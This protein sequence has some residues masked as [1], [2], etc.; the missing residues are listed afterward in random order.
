[1]PPRTLTTS[2]PMDCP[3]T[4]AL[5]VCVDAERVVAIRAGG[6]HPDTNGFICTKISRFDRRLEHSD[7]LLYPLRR[8][9]LKGEGAFER[10]TWDEAVREITRRFK[11]IRHEWGGEAIL[12]Y[13]YGGSN[14]ALTD[15]FADRL[16]FARLGASRLDKTICAA[17]TTALAVA[18]YG[19]MPGVAFGDFPEARCIVVWG[20]NPR[21]SNIHLMPFL[22]EAKRRG[23]FIAVVDPVRNFSTRE[24][25]LHLPVRPGGDLPLA[26]ALIRWWNERGMLDRGFL[27]RHADGLDTLL[28]AAEEWSLERA[29]GEAGLEAESILRLAEAYAELSPALI[30]IGWGLER[31][32]N[33]GHAVA[34]IL[35]MPA[36][37]GKFGVRGGGYTLSNNG[38]V[39]FDSDEVLG[40]HGWD[41]RKVN[42]TR[43]GEAL[44][45]GFDPPIKGLF[46]YNCNPAVSVPDQGA[47]LAGLARG[48]LFTVVLDQVMTDTARYADVVLPATTFLEHRDVRV[49]YGAYVV[50]G[51]APVVAR[52][53]EAKPNHEVFG[54]L[55]RAMGWGDDAFAWPEEVAARRIIE[56]L[57]ADGVPVEGERVERGGVAPY[58]FGGATPIQFGN[59]FPATPNGRIQLAPPELGPRPY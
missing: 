48:D 58:G 54:W 10:I 7:R 3:D 24:V 36:L 29:A 42:M 20:A 40:G 45:D 51:V 33:G 57:S 2:C 14:G 11:E 52:R 55:A 50:G 31:N 34:A 49:S 12:P 38:A 21:V 46:V 30:R 15:G 26:L 59:V 1:M 9:G 28:G 41:T 47:V 25:D 37:L 19:K 8:T 16:Y 43:L 22:R 56:H 5:E 4:C 23:A 35:A 39:R 13:H 27:A 6:G 53:G 17:P 18:M 32:A 44:S